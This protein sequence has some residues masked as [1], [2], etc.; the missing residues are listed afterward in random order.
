MTLALAWWRFKPKWQN[1]LWNYLR[2]RLINLATFWILDA[3]LVWG[4]II[5]CSW[6]NVYS[7]EVLSAAGHQWVGVDISSSMLGMNR[8]ISCL[9]FC[10]RCKT[11]GLW[12]RS[13]LLGY[14]TWAVF[15]TWYLWWCHKV[16][17][18]LGTLFN[19]LVYPRCNG[20]AIKIRFILWIAVKPHA[21]TVG[22]KRSSFAVKK[23]FPIVI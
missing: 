3:G 18:I 8:C 10:R 13:L 20:Y 21:N 15:Q 14:G 16:W 9:T 5:F 23:V 6:P 22:W 7:G 17:F 11:T 1:E 4:R 12:R 19:S 2:C